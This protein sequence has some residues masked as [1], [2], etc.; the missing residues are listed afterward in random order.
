M[1]RRARAFTDSLKPS[2]RRLMESQGLFLLKARVVRQ[3]PAGWFRWLK[4]PDG[5]IPSSATWYVDGSLLDGPSKVLSVTGYSIVV[6]GD[7]GQLIGCAHGAPPS[8]VASA[9][10]AEAFA[11]YKVLALNPFVPEI[12]TDCLGVLHALMRGPHDATAANRVNARLWKLIGGCLDGTSWQEAARSVTWM[13][14][15]GSRATIGTAMKSSGMPIT[16]ID[17]RANRLAD[18]LAKAAAARFRI[19]HQI[20]N[21][22]KTAF[23]AYEHAA[24]VAGIVTHAANNHY[25]SVTTPDGAYAHRRQRDA[26]P[27]ARSSN[28][29]QKKNSEPT[30]TATSRTAATTLEP[31][32]T[33]TTA[34]DTAHKRKNAAGNA[35]RAATEQRD[36]RFLQT[37]HREM[38]NRPRVAAAGP[39]AQER[40][41]ALQLRVRAKGLTAL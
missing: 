11:L 28:P 25:T 34:E 32:P 35:L 23:R 14:A 27:P 15:H 10:A 39:T 40:L 18:A 38:A 1:D 12:V 30:T 31:S 4:Q 5:D 21:T 26:Q 22:V 9:G 36:A 37:W 41:L 33:T 2:R 7:D 17:W 16:A 6:V 20:Q 19:P 13:P 24:M 8:W 3:R 29:A